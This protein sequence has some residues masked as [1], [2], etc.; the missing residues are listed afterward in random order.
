MYVSAI[1]YAMARSSLCKVETGFGRSHRRAVA[2]ETRREKWAADPTADIWAAVVRG[3]GIRPG[4]TCTEEN[5]EMQNSTHEV[6]PRGLTMVT[7]KNKSTGEEIT[8][9]LPTE[10]RDKLV[11]VIMNRD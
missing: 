10:E 8:L 7:I 6:I 5:C 9:R 1:W 3:A 4:V 2:D 11:D